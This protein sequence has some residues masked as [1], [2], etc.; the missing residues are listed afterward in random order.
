MTS[1]G[2][3][4]KLFWGHAAGK[5]ADDDN[6]FVAAVSNIDTFA[7]FISGSNKLPLVSG[8]FSFSP[9]HFLLIFF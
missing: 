4:Q 6:S 3:S 9:M 1:A 2:D 8:P 5:W 7:A